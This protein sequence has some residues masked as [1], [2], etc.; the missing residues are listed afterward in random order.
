MSSLKDIS[1]TQ[2]IDYI[3]SSSS[4][5]EIMKKCGIKTLTRSLQRRINN[6]DKNIIS[7]LPKFYGGI[8]SKIAKHS[9]EYYKELIAKS[10]NWDE[11]M[12]ELKFT[13]LQIFK[14]VNFPPG[15]IGPRAGVS[16]PPLKGGTLN[17]TRSQWHIYPK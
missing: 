8:Y 15:A 17:Q 2:L 1:D 14:K 3:K 7:H 9:D 16:P 10:E 4:W 11:V 13:T 12:S 5:N 6:L